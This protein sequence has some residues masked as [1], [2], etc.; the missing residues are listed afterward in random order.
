MKML[1]FLRLLQ[2][3]RENGYKFIF[4]KQIRLRPEND[5]RPSYAYCLRCRHPAAKPRSMFPVEAVWHYHCL[6]GGVVSET[7]DK[8]R[9]CQAD[10]RTQRRSGLPGPARAAADLDLSTKRLGLIMAAGEEY[11]AV[12]PERAKKQEVLR[13]DLLKAAGVA[14]TPPK[15]RKKPEGDKPPRKGPTKSP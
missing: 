5:F 13:R 7:T 8:L 10:E 2:E 15:K 6:L 1:E 9:G 3:A 12:E 14:E 11:T 4:R